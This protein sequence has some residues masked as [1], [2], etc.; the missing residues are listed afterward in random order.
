MGDR[1]FALAEIDPLSK[2]MPRTAW[3]KSN[4][5][6]SFH[7]LWRKKLDDMM[8]K[9]GRGATYRKQAHGKGTDIDD[10]PAEDS[11]EFNF[12][13]AGG[14]MEKDTEAFK[15]ITKDMVEA[16]EAMQDAANDMCS[17]QDFMNPKFTDI[18]RKVRD[19]RMTVT[20]ELNN[21]LKTMGDVRKFFLESDHKEEMKRLTEFVE[22]GERM[23]SLI[24]D[25][26]MDAVVDVAIKLAVQEEGE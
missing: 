4:K 11:I 14:T 1:G 21:A 13:M 23:K 5:E 6:D 10:V 25:G 18:V 20:T 17:L 2:I 22:L 3:I 12:F 24:L 7:G 19:T 16:K 9:Y 8:H 15:Q 26:T